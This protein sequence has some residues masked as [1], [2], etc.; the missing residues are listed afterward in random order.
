MTPTKR[1]G[2]PG[3]LAFDWNGTLVDDTGR[4]LRATNRVLRE[5][6]LAPLGEPGFRAAFTLPMREFFARLGIAEQRS[7]EAEK[8]WNEEMAA[9][10]APLS[11]GAAE[12][13]RTAA[14]CGV[15]VVVVSAA[16]SQ[17]VL[18]DARRLGVGHLLADVV[19]SAGDKA[20]VLSRLVAG[21][22]GPVVYVGDVEYD[23]RSA[24]AAGA[25]P[26]G[27]GRGYRPAAALAEAGAEV[28]VWNL[29]SL[30]MLFT[31]VPAA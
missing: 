4:A 17:S 31:G 13:L 12:I 9:E 29:A 22:R 27:F 3:V 15:H 1:P 5:H 25:Y 7:D 30:G 20:A 2:R 24:F 11:P 16:S 28:V 8:R 10:T 14:D 6:G 18:S 19:G 26:V 23:I 21:G